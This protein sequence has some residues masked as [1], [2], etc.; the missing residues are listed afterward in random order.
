MAVFR[1]GRATNSPNGA[2]DSVRDAE[3]VT[4]S[5]PGPERSGLTP[6]A[7]W[8]EAL[9]S[10]QGLAG[11][12]RVPTGPVSPLF[13]GVCRYYHDCF[14]ADS[15]GGVLNNVLDKNQAE[16]LVFADG[17]EALIT[18]LGYRMEVPLSLGVTA[19]NAAD[20][21]RREK[22]LVYGSVF[23]VGRGPNV[24]RKKGDLYCAP[25]LFWPARIEQEGSRAFLSID[26]EEQHI[27]FPLLA[28]LIDSDSEEQAQAYAEAILSQVPTAPFDVN[29]IREF[30][31]VVAELIPDL[32]TDDLQAFPALQ[33]E[34]ALRDL[35]EHDSPVQLLCASA[36][37]LV[38]RP[39]EAR[40]VLTELQVMAGRGEMSTPLAAVFDD[41][42]RAKPGTPAPASRPLNAPNRPILAGAELTAAQTRVLRQAER[43]P[44]TLVIGPPGTGKS[45]TIAQIILDAVARGQTVLL[46]SKMNKAVDVVVEKLTPHLGGLTVILRGG[47]RRYRDELKKFLDNLFD[48]TGAPAKPRAGEIEMLEERLRA[49]DAELAE[50]T[51]EI[52]EILEREGS[53]TRYVAE[54]AAIQAPAYDEDAAASMGPEAL[55]STRDELRKLDGGKSSLFGW[56][57]GKRRDQLLGDLAEQLKLDDA[58]LGSLDEI[59]Q[60]ETARANLLDVEDALADHDDLNVL[61]TRHARLR[62]DRGALVG[63]LLGLRRR[64]ALAEALRLN[65]RTLALFKTA[66]E[67]R[68]T[69]EQDKI[70][71]EL[72]FSALLG[73]FPIWATTNPHAAEIMPLAHEMFDLVIIDEASQCDVAS[74]LPL[75]YRAKRAIVCGDPKQLRHLSWLREDRQAALASQHGLSAS[76]RSQWNYRTHSLLDVVN[77][78]LPSQDDVV[79]LD[80]H[81]RS[82]PQIIEFSN[83]RFYGGAFRVMTRRPDTIGARSVELR[84]I[85]GTRNKHGYNVEEADAILKEIEKIAKAQAKKPANERSS[86]GVL[87][88]YRDQVNYLNRTL[89]AKLKSKTL[90]DHDIICGTAHT[91]QGDERDV[92]L[93]SFCAD[94][95]SHR[96][97]VTFL[98]NDNL[99]NVA[100]T[101]AR[102]R[103]VIFTALDPRNLP[104][105]HLLREYLT[106]AADC[107]EP[108]DPRPDPNAGTT[109]SRALAS[110]LRSH[111]GYTTWLDY[112]V[113]GLKI[114]VVAQH[115]AQAL[116]IAADGDPE[117]SATPDSGSLERVGAEAI[118]ERAGWRVYRLPYRR[119]QR[120]REECLAEID[121]LL[122]G[123]GG[124]D[125][126]TDAT[127]A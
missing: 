103:Q 91:F 54:F 90:Q 11:A 14:S 126:E 59:A 66:L 112:P 105:E 74:A 77:G 101:R 78:A 42:A 79:L 100:V 18:G 84:K 17:D 89:A 5:I 9:A 8:P 53:W 102:R 20:V 49:A 88:P 92:M 41:I 38:R 37:A 119:W 72:D 98:N 55:Q 127:S 96:S 95:T 28:S 75:L 39:T 25:L 16:Y 65:R 107:L 23:L 2:T 122:G 1:R 116:A 104:T 125:E 40:G 52:R 3:I 13:A 15:R 45:F 69:A 22:F 94:P 124:E 83:R 62:A 97:T 118:L 99:F 81:Y 21:N 115:G 43:R 73:A 76:Q 109:Y 117:A 10:L 71:A 113:A 93:I 26:L 121:A 6:V 70:F 110:A 36:M 30:A 12:E 58:A 51:S 7:E 114:D 34:D 61:F 63:E 82:L 56:S 68:S 24:G 48:G 27:N 32:R 85:N 44:L 33:T 46:S 31:A 87:S 67:A 4:G 86:I 108:D 106:Y 50:L 19:Q 111:G 64:D 80:E 60:R 120:E 47:D 123:G 29:V 57:R 35:I